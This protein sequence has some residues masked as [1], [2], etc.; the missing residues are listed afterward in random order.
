MVKKNN[1]E[2]I[3]SKN[4]VRQL[5]TDNNLILNFSDIV[6][7]FSE[8]MIEVISI[9]IDVDNE[10]LIYNY[11]E[12]DDNNIKIIFY[13][14][15]K[16]VKKVINKN[17]EI[18]LKKAQKISENAKFD[19]IVNKPLKHKNLIS[20]KAIHDIKRLIK[21]KC[22]KIRNNQIR[23]RM[24]PLEGKLIIGE[25]NSISDKYIRVQYKDV[26]GYFPKFNQIPN[27]HI[28]LNMKMEFYVEKVQD[29]HDS[30]YSLVFSRSS[31]EFLEKVMESEIPEIS[32]GIIEIVEIARVA[33]IR[34]KVL[35]K[36]NEALIQPVASCIGIRGERIN[37]I[38]R[39][40]ADEKIDIIK[41]TD[42][43]VDLI[44]NIYHN[45]DVLKITNE[46]NVYKI[47]VYD[48]DINQ[49]IGKHGINVK[50]A[51]MLIKSKVIIISIDEAIKQ[52]YKIQEQYI[53]EESDNKKK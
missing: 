21:N 15:L 31:N 23:K 39:R 40:C 35:V 36:S 10:D 50:L 45:I 7:L 53:E 2:I 32:D 18:S 52:G 28:D 41:W 29:I 48:D 14:K 11:E 26:Y 33:G 4:L 19:D 37:N 42:N 1:N 20:R 51:S 9:E 3:I 25:V 46:D 34:S 30:I 17:K 27:E 22:F 38:S 5:A 12:Y 16:V 8:S 43:T 13:K 44:N 6:K 49:A 47:I 24:L